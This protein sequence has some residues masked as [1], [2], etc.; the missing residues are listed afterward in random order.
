MQWNYCHMVI[1]YLT[2]WETSR[3]FQLNEPFYIPTSYVWGLHFLHFDQIFIFF[4][5]KL[6]HCIGYEVVSHCSFGLYV[7]KNTIEH[8]FVC[9]LGSCIKYFLKNWVVFLIKSF[10]SSLFCILNSYMICKYFTQLPFT[11]L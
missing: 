9:L 1:L 4:F 11:F 2:F 10:K 6:S 8:L 7:P 3:L 5:K